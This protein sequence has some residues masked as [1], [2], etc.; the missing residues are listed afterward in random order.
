MMFTDWTLTNSGYFYL[1]G[2]LYGV[3]LATMFW[4]LLVPWIQKRAV[5]DGA[6]GVG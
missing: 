6:K 1:R 2:V 5:L 3:V 4:K